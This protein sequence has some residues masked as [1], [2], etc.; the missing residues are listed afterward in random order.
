MKHKEITNGL[1]QL[2]FDSG[3]AVTGDEIT[4][5]ENSEPQPTLAAIATAATKWAAAQEAKAQADATA[6]AALLAKLGITADQFNS[7]LG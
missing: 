5:W 7:L 4:L 3:W 1:Q 2:G 6:K